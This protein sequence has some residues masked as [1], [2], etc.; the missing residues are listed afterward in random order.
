ML[1]LLSAELLDQ[2]GLSIP[3]DPRIAIRLVIEPD[4]EPQVFLTPSDGD[5]GPFTALIMRRI[6]ES[7]APKVPGTY[8]WKVRQYSEL[9]TFADDPSAARFL[10]SLF[11]RDL[12]PAFEAFE[13]MVKRL[14]TKTELE[15]AVDRGVNAMLR[16]MLDDGK[17]IDPRELRLSTVCRDCGET[18]LRIRELGLVEPIRELLQAALESAERLGIPDPEIQLQRLREIT[19]AP[20]PKP[21]EFFAR[22]AVAH[23]HP[24]F[25]LSVQLMNEAGNSVLRERAMSV[26]Q[27]FLTK[28]D[29][30]TR[31]LREAMGEL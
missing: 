1:S 27:A 15:E 11:R 16:R 4:K 5:N 8:I 7:P 29:A 12:A 22:S 2:C 28:A 26:A 10:F 14:P 13:E 23:G 9:V 30:F 6:Q 18:G 3:D 20:T 17:A 21:N 31:D 19:E 25:V 24:Y